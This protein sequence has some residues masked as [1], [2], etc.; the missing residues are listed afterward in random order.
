MTPATSQREGPSAV[1]GKLPKEHIAAISCKKLG[2]TGQD[3]CSG[4]RKRLAAKGRWRIPLKLQRAGEVWAGELVV[5]GRCWVRTGW[6]AGRAEAT[7]LRCL[8]ATPFNLDQASKVCRPIRQNRWHYMASRKA[9]R[10]HPFYGLISRTTP[11]LHD[12][13]ATNSDTILFS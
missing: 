7:F 11:F 3:L 12:G 8:P 10:K 1:K 13:S 6:W 9:G 4:G 5:V 2:P